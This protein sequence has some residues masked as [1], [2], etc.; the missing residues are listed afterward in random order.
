MARQALHDTKE[1]YGV[2]VIVFVAVA[3]P[4]PSAAVA[5]IMTVCAEVTALAVRTPE[6]DI[7]AYSE[8]DVIDQVIGLPVYVTECPDWNVA[9]AVK[10]AFPPD[11][12]EVEPP[13][14]S[15]FNGFDQTAVAIPVPLR[16]PAPN[17]SPHPVVP[18]R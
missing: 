1:S 4:P 10:V 14:A 17:L 5:L 7:D 9:V 15:D 8:P 12:T 2:M 6:S 13:T 11:A 3:V 16:N 18:D